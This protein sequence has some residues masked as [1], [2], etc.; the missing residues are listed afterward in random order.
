MIL[1]STLNLSGFF[2]GRMSQSVQT[3]FSPKMGDYFLPPFRAGYIYFTGA[4]R[5]LLQTVHR[6]YMRRL[7][8]QGESK[9]RMVSLATVE[10]PKRNAR[11]NGRVLFYAIVVF[12][13]CW[14]QLSANVLVY[15]I[16][17]QGPATTHAIR[18][19]MIGN[20]RSINVR[21][22]I[23]TNE[24]NVGNDI[25]TKEDNHLSFE[26]QLSELRD[27]LEDVK[28]NLEG[29]IRTNEEASLFYSHGNKFF[30]SKRKVFVPFTIRDAQRTV[31]TQIPYG[32]EVF[33]FVDVYAANG[34]QNQTNVTANRIES[35][36]NNYT[37]GSFRIPTNS[38][39]RLY[40]NGNPLP[41]TNNDKDDSQCL[42]YSKRCYRSKF[43]KV[44]RY[45]LSLQKKRQD[46]DDGGSEYYYFYM[47]A[48]NDLCV[49]LIDIRD[50]AFEHQRYFI[51]TGIGASGWIMSQAFL[52]DF[53]KFWTSIDV[54]RK[55]NELG[56]TPQELL[57]PDSVA[58]FLLKQKSAWS[59]TRQYLTSH[60]I[61]SGSTKDEASIA[62][63]FETSMVN[64][65][66][67]PD[68]I[69]KGKKK[70]KKKK[71]TPEEAAL[72]APLMEPARYLPRCLEPHRG[73]WKDSKTNYFDAYHWGFFDYDLC[74]ESTIFP[75]QK[76][77]LEELAKKD[78]YFSNN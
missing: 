47:E 67:E 5:F 44:I 40:H 66:K 72:H 34:D 74:P 68:N 49:P 16:R 19:P 52:V 35:K 50:L 8:G 41:E 51:H 77:Q 45:L 4:N 30:S 56:L 53:Y 27:R 62:A 25:I 31:P 61:L 17:H 24:D 55:N 59:V 10:D 57:E 65:T 69:D 36:T 33:D 71:E 75:C 76:G 15:F 78:P 13:V 46:G 3:P 64:V 58:A 60:S 39:A 37:E 29:E 20:I 28:N 43:L 18:F 48:D 73:I 54:N 23:I 42:Q 6:Y 22:D 11:Q 9:L 12:G 26:A 7:T 63:L 21:S 2:T 70:K 38:K 14:I 1:P 32:F